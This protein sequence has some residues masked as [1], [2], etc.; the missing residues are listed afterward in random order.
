MLVDDDDDMVASTR[1]IKWNGL[2]G[3]GIDKAVSR[4]AGEEASGGGLANPAD[5]YIPPVDA[6]EVAEKGVRRAAAATDERRRR[7]GCGGN[8]DEALLAID[9]DADVLRP[10]LGAV[11]DVGVGTDPLREGPPPPPPADVPNDEVEVEG[12]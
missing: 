9:D 2:R 7:R 11:N 1:R 10:R 4:E 12:R 3:G 8:E 5:K 6:W